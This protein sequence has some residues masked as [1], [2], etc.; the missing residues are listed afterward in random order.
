MFIIV[1]NTIMGLDDVVVEFAWNNV[2]TKYGNSYGALLVI[3][4]N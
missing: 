2:I 1:I 4:S 3:M